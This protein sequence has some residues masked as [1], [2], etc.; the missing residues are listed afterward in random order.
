MI[1]LEDVKKD[2]HIRVLLEY[3]DRFTGTI[4]YTEHGYR[5]AQLVA[6]RAR[7]VLSQLDFGERMAE[8]AAIAGYLHDIG[9]VVNRDDHHLASVMIAYNRLS[10][11]GMES[12]ELAYVMSAIAC[13][14]EQSARLMNEVAAALLIA[15]KSDVHR[16]RVRK[17][18]LPREGE[19][20]QDIHDRVNYSV[21]ESSLTVNKLSREIVLELSVDTAIS[22]VMEYFEIFLERMMLSREAS[23]FLEGNFKF[24]INGNLMI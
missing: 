22:S 20:I 11:L 15:D 7:E 2:N 21:T 10:F 18:D 19:S 13:H 3:A 16:S 4:G 12:D 9:N 23:S 8:L 24:F 1:E 5:H 6:E 17:K 14:E